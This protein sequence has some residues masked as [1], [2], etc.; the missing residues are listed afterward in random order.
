V[1]FR[2]FVYR[3]AQR[4]GIVGWVRNVGGEVLIHAQGPAASLLVFGESLRASA[5]PAARVSSARML[6]AA[7]EPLVGFHIHASGAEPGAQVHVPADLFTCADCLAEMRDPA[8][9]RYRYPFINCTQCGPRYTL[10]GALPYDRINTSMCVFSLCAACTAEY[11]E[12]LDRRFHA[13]PLACAHCGPALRWQADGTSL[14]GSEPALAAAIAALRSGRIVALRGVGGYHLLC[15]ATQAAAVS[16]LRMR[17]RRPAKPLAVIVPWR[18]SDGLAYADRLAQLLP[19]HRAALL[20]PARPLVLAPRRADADVAEGIAPGMAEIALMLPYSPLLVLLLDEF[21]VAVVATSGNRSGEPVLTSPREAEQGLAGVADGF[22]HHDRDIVRPAEDPLMRLVAGAVRPLRLGRGTAPLELR[23]PVPVDSPTLAVG[24]FGKNTV[25]LAWGDRAVV[26]P[27][28]GDQ[29]SARA[30]SA[31]EQVCSDLQRLYGVVARRVVHDAHPGFP[32]SRW[33]RALGL[34]ARAVWHHHAH[35]S[36]LAGEFGRD[37]AILCFAWDGNGLGPDRT[38]WGGEAL[39]GRPGAWRRV[40]SFRAF[41]LPGGESAMR[42][43]W[44]SALALSW[45]GGLAWDGRKAAGLDGAALDTLRAA[46]DARLNAP[47]TSSVGRLFDAAAAYLEVCTT[48]SFDGEAPMRLEALAAGAPLPARALPLPLNRDT[49]AIWRADWRPLVDDLL[50]RGVPPAARAAHF[51]ARLAQTLCEQAIR[52]RA[53][54]GVQC[55]GLCGG[56][57]QNALLAARVHD[58]LGEAG[59]AVLMPQVLPVNDAAISY[60]QLVEA[61]AMETVQAPPVHTVEAADAG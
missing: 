49:E 61:A 7:A 56:V 3:L 40:A 52:V 43:P 5:P 42:Q 44:R 8:A 18:G 32:N 27:H 37:D 25:A 51:H 33:A 57:F 53:Q 12:P 60:G 13:Q 35:A 39:L 2:P 59:F 16:R 46:H 17:K 47:A 28:I 4:H 36:A 48:A 26:S 24:A 9:R 21:G 30:Q 54:S 50:D 1:G 23:L 29:G 11:R 19:A 15:D 55:I 58:L 38:L 20:D 14:A 31:L 45:E 6:P 34:P 10:I 41:R 22:L